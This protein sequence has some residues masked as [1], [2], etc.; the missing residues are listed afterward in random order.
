MP[1]AL[2][3]FGHPLADRG[4]RVALPIG[5]VEW[6]EKG[7][8]LLLGQR[9]GRGSVTSLIYLGKCMEHTGVPD[10]YDSNVWVDVSF[11]HAIFVSGTR[12]S[13]KSF[14]IGVFVESLL[15]PP[16]SKVSTS[17]K[18]AAV[19]ILDPQNQFW[20][21]GRTPT[22]TLPED[23]VHFTLLSGW[24]LNPS[25]IP[26]VRVFVCPGDPKP[27]GTELEMVI[28]TSDLTADDLCA[29][30]RTDVYSPQGHL[31]ATVLDKV[32]KGG[33]SAVE[34]TEKG[35]S[36]LRKVPPKKDFTIE[37]LITCLDEDEEILS[38]IATQTVDAVRWRFESLHRT[39]L[40]GPAGTPVIDLL[41]EGQA[42]VV[43]LRSVDDATKALVGGLIVKKI[44]ETMGSFHSKRKVMRRLGREQEPGSHLPGRVW[45][46][47]D[48]A[49]LFCPGDSETSSTR[50]IVEYVKRGRDAG[51]SLLM[52]TQQPSAVNSRVLSQI[53]LALVHRLT[54][55]G[56]ISSALARIPASLP[57]SFSVGQA[58][59]DA[60]ALVRL[61]ESGEAILG[62]AQVDR[63]FLCRI[64]PRLTA[65]GGSEP[66]A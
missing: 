61:L 28:A 32:G 9:R 29:F 58:S 17:E 10:Y 62:D 21:L 41:R 42:T 37:D 66:G 48:E 53:D 30:W 25:A 7:K 34:T 63:A 19:L 5:R 64:R 46:V 16:G 20:T 65:H 11:P 1:G 60:R 15:L 18:P 50:S 43:M 3:T 45:C 4:I 36:L 35:S 23:S 54:F 13:G 33:Y 59:S 55:E 39:G 8:H 38:K 22:A 24:G 26:N 2:P 27:I 51:L 12:G 56:D 47:V 52:A 31:V 44:Y 14:D 57:P 49:H 40:F 6:I